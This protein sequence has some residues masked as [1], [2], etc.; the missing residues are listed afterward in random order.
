M[1]QGITFTVT[2][3]APVAY[4]YTCVFHPWMNGD[5]VV[6][7]GQIRRPVLQGSALTPYGPVTSL[8]WAR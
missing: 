7:Q 1:T 5:A 3:A 2:F 4:V 6:K 8:V